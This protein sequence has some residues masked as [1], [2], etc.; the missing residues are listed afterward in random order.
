MVREAPY[1]TGATCLYLEYLPGKR[2]TYFCEG[3]PALAGE[4]PT[5]ARGNL[6][7]IGEVPTFSWKV[8][9]LTM[10]TFLSGDSNYPNLS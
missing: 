1:L 5:L 9:M 8:S 4:V 2:A 3:V 7:W 10:G 6:P